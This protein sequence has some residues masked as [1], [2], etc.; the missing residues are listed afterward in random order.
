MAATPD[1]GR[2]WTLSLDATTTL[3]MAW[4]PPGSFEMGSAAYEPGR[5]A[6]E[7]PEMRVMLTHGYWMGRTPVTIAEWR[8]VM[9]VDVRGQLGKV[10]ADDTLYSFGDKHETVR[11]LIGMSREAGPD[12][13]LMN[14][15]GDLP[16][17]F[18]SWLDATEFCRR[19][20][21]RERAAGRLPG[22]YAYRLPTEA[23]WEYA[24]RAGSRGATYADSIGPS[25]DHA[26]SLNDLAWYS[27]NSA[28]GYAGRGWRVDGKLAGPRRVATKLPNSWGLYDMLGNVWE[29]CRDWY[30]PYPGG[31]LRD[32]TGPVTGQLRVNRGGSFG[33]AAADERASR[34]AGNPPAEASAFRGFRVVLARTPSSPAR[35]VSGEATA[36]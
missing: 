15:D 21:V 17:Y 20:T 7:S 13:Y 36:N 10:L 25:G 30:G 29:W 11:A 18:V 5:S 12:A 32:P 34:R 19:L 2:P 26:N 23:E 33:S 24:S 14:E 1:G 4:I 28:D 35:S 27:A 8:A 16:I 9:G 3:A 22:H 31:T 6:D